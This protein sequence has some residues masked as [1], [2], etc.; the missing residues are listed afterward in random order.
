MIHARATFTPAVKL[1]VLNCSALLV[2]PQV[3]T[4]GQKKSVREDLA[5]AE[6]T[7]NYSLAAVTVERNG[8]V[9]VA[10]VSNRG[11][12]WV[13]VKRPLNKEHLNSPDGKREVVYRHGLRLLDADSHQERLI[14]AD[15]SCWHQC[16]APDSRRLVYSSGGRVRIY[17]VVSGAIT[18]LAEGESA[19]WSPDGKWIE[20]EF[21]NNFCVVSPTG[22]ASRQIFKSKSAYGVSWSPD[23]RFL[24]YIKLGGSSGGFFIWGMKCPEPYRVWVVRVDD[25]AA[26]WVQ[27]TCKPGFPFEW[28]K[29]S[30]LVGQ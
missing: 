30:D 25:W 20:F 26:D 6:R 21:K 5:E 16:W 23:S 15:G 2:L 7:G 12:M 18:D 22:G 3:S 10:S 28:V 17:D 1:L 11:G 4:A 29:N 13:K 27:N 19:R 24:S 14:D 9:W 8:E